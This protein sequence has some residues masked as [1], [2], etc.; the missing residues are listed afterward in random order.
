MFSSVLS[1][2]STLSFVVAVGVLG[3]GLSF[4]GA[5]SLFVAGRACPQAVYIVRGWGA[6]VWCHRG[7]SCCRHTAP[8]VWLPRRPVGN[9]APVSGCEKGWRREV[10]TYKGTIVICL[11]VADDNKLSV[12]VC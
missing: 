10:G 8:F 9:V 7:G 12:R 11:L 4:M 1:L 3:A 2:S 5:G 6:D